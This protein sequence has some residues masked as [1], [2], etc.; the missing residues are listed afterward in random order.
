MITAEDI[1]IVLDAYYRYRYDTDGTWPIRDVRYYEEAE[2]WL[3]EQGC[4]VD[5]F[6]NGGA[7]ENTLWED[8]SRQVEFYLKYVR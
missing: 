7:R 8:Q 4:D 2:I 5:I 6:K 1:G 3:T